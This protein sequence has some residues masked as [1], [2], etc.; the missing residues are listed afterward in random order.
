MTAGISRTADVFAIG[1]QALRNKDLAQAREAFT[2]ATKADPSMCDAWLG[3]MAA[4]DAGVDVV[5]GAYRSR[6]NFG[7]LLK[8]SDMRVEQLGVKTSL[9]LGTVAFGF[10]VNREAELAMAYAVALAEATPPQLA[11]SSAILEAQKRRPAAQPFDQDLIDYAHIGLLGLARRWPDVLTA[12]SKVNWRIAREPQYGPVVKILDAAVLLWKV[13]ALMGTGAPADAQRWAESCLEQ[14]GIPEDLNGKLRLA[15]GYALRAQGKR[16]EA[17]QAFT[18]LKAWLDT[19]EVREAL[20]NPDKTVELVTAESLATRTDVWDPT[21]GQSASDLQT[22]ERESKRSSVRAEALAEL[23]AQIGMDSVKNQIKR[24]EARNAMDA[25]RHERGVGTKRDVAL[26]Y[27]FVGGPGTGKTTMARVLAKLLF[28][29]GLIARP[30]VTEASRPQLVGKYL[31]HSA[32]KTNGV[33]D[34]ALGGLLFIDEAYSLFAKGYSDGDA[35]GEEVVNTLLARIEN[36]RTTADPQKKLAVVIAGYEADIDRFLSMNDGL[37]GRFNTRIRFD[38]Y[39]AENL[40]A[41]ADKMAAA[42]DSL[43]SGEAQDLLRRN[44]DQLTAITI[45]DLDPNTNQPRQISGIDKAGNARFVRLITEK[46]TEVRDLRNSSGD[47][48]LT[49]LTAEDLV[50]LTASDVEEA[51]RD[52]CATQRIPFP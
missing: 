39:S 45:D 15:R 52:A 29:L 28:G 4:G 40:I 41:I 18:E 42:E 38:S 34:K 20:D 10:G 44:L 19:P 31:G 22:E 5:A 13:W 12:V 16:E 48:D 23:D 6:G 11:A 43:Y 1:L 24:L 49:T 47:V 33:I 50:T 26:S 3:R 30:E 14:A 8:Q 9:T 35:Y 7:Q 21:S 32:D 2:S 27:V 46:A 17:T 25:L 51:F 36:E 37:P